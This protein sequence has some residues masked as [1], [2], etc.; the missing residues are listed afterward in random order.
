MVRNITYSSRNLK[1]PNFPEFGSF[2]WVKTWFVNY[3]VN[4]CDFQFAYYCRCHNREKKSCNWGK[5]N[6]V[7]IGVGCATM[8]I[9][10]KPWLESDRISWLVSPAWHPC[11]TSVAAGPLLLAMLPFWRW[12][13]NLPAE[14]SAWKSSS[15]SDRREGPWLLSGDVCIQWNQ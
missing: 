8:S 14:P 4:G 3:E 13:A 10:M 7:H 9:R 11:P 5:F 2:C 1:I 15:S 12:R 6:I